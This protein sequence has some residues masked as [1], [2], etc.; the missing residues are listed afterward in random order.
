[1]RRHLTWSF[2]LLTW[3][4]PGAAGAAGAAEG[5]QVLVVVGPSNHPAGTHEVLAGGRLLKQCLEHSPNVPGLMV[6]VVDAWPTDQARLQ[7]VKT[8]VFIGDTFP[9]Q[10]FPDSSANLATFATLM[11]RG[12]G[13]VCVHFATGLRKADIP[14]DGNHP[15]LGWLG[16]YF[17]DKAVHHQSIARIFPAATITPAVDHPVTRGW[18][19]FTLHDEPYI[20][21]YFGP[22]GNQP[23]ANVT[24][25]AVAQL[26]PEAPKREIVSWCVQRADGGRGFGVVMPHFYRNWLQADLRRLI[27][28]GIVWSAQIEVPANGV[29]SAEPDLVSFMPGSLEPQPWKKPATK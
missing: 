9:L 24:A 3:L 26:P 10:R 2:L 29:D 16:G 23:A 18:K 25:I 19:E 1:M 6:E 5:A 22:D 4:L 12:A 15:L 27:L 14:A 13:V 7:A 8:F 21:N 11:Q 20:N 28:N 17:A